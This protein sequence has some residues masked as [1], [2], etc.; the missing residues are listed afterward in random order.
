MGTVTAIFADLPGPKIRIGLLGEEPLILKR[1]EEVSLTTGDVVGTPSL[2]PVDYDKL[3]EIVSAGDTIYLNDGFIQLGVLGT[4][5]EEIRCSIIIGGKLLSHK[6]LNLPGIEVPLEP[7]TEKDLDLAKSILE[8]GVDGLSISFVEK[9]QDVIRIRDFAQELGRPVSIIAKI[10]RGGAVKNIDEILREADGIMIARGD[11]G[12]EVPIEDVPGIQKNLICRANIF[13]KPVIT[14]TQ[15]LESM[16]GNVRPTRAEVTDVANAILDGTDAVMLSEETA[17]GEY[18]VEAC[19]MMAKIAASI[20]PKRYDFV[21]RPDPRDLWLNDEA[22]VE[23]VISLNAVVASHTLKTNFILAPTHSGSTPRHISRF[24]P[25]S[26]ILS[27]SED[28][29]VRNFLVLSWGVRPYLVDD[30]EDH[31]AI[32]EWLRRSGLARKGDRAILTAGISPEVEEADSLSVI[33][34]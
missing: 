27:F 21:H 18:P 17:I 8:E 4:S 14:A 3:P 31:D 23:D 24:K 2:I 34:L 22:T 28:L 11:L 32:I 26:W 15:M 6:G 1:G 13:A 9:A 33:S 25:D 30:G 5:E 12:T 20:E 29:R 19:Q 16:V 10:E 7:V